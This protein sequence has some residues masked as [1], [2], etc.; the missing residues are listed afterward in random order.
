VQRSVE[1]LRI[2]VR[3]TPKGGRDALEGWAADGTGAR[4]LKA[5]VA[6]PAEDG[7]ANLALRALIADALG[8]APSK[9]AI[10]AGAS[11]R[12]KRLE[13]EGD[14]MALAARLARKA[15]P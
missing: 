8:V 6:A 7:K 3:L 9:V 14:P 4:H 12:W 15:G 2:S 11:A 5:R 1:K 10:V 13:I